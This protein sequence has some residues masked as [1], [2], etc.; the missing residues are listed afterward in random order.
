M[1]SWRRQKV[2]FLITLLGQPNF[3]F[4]SPFPTLPGRKREIISDAVIGTFPQ[5]K[6]STY[7][8]SGEVVHSTNRV[9]SGERWNLIGTFCFPFSLVANLKKLLFMV[10]WWKLE[11]QFSSFLDLPLELQSHIISFTTMREFANLALLNSAFHRLMSSDE[12]WRNLYLATFRSSET[13]FKPGN[14][15]KDTDSS[16]WKGKLKNLVSAVTAS[17]AKPTSST[18]N[19]TDSISWKE[20]F[21]LQFS[22]LKDTQN[23][24]DHAMRAVSGFPM[25]VGPP[26]FLVPREDGSYPTAAVG[27]ASRWGGSRTVQLPYSHGI[28]YET[29]D[30]GYGMRVPSP[31]LTER[32]TA[33]FVTIK[34]EQQ[35]KKASTHRCFLQ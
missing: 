32:V 20:K 3:L 2:I 24:F 22:D 17:P 8:H 4:C 30:I 15:E 19:D 33:H 10:V 35:N 23:T 7:L 25:K 28:R 18:E 21:R 16:S 31:V 5:H 13:D 12:L 29:T 11:S 14:A 6:G 9:S 1:H 34:S 26:E 27:R